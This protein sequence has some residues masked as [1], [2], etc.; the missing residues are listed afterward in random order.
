LISAILSPLI[1]SLA[2]IR[3]YPLDELTDHFNA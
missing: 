1:K 3:A 2:K